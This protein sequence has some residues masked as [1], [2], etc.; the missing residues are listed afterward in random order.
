MNSTWGRC[1]R[2]C[3]LH[4]A[5][6]GSLH[7]EVR[8]S[9]PPKCST[10]QE[11]RVRCCRMLPLLHPMSTDVHW[12][13]PFG[14]GRGVM[15]IEFMKKI[16]KNNVMCLSKSSIHIELPKFIDKWAVHKYW[17]THIAKALQCTLSV[18]AASAACSGD[19]WHHL[20]HLHNLA[21]RM[22]GLCWTFDATTF[23]DMEGT[24]TQTCGVQ[25]RKQ[26]FHGKGSVAF[27]A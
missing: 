21:T 4:L 26:P 17:L 9:H 13:V 6:N 3:R 2:A 23:M 24:H 14:F 22:V 27:E 18:L 15:W 19:V 11:P 8:S 5:P 16:F 12:C 20:G 25:I 10:L 1:A 7:E